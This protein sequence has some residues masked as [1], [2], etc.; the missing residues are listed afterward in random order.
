MNVVKAGKKSSWRSL[1][2]KERDSGSGTGSN[3]KNEGRQVEE[4]GSS[5]KPGYD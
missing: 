5:G 2:I 3:W 4:K 1:D